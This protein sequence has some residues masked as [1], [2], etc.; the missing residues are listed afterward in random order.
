MGWLGDWVTAR[1]PLDV[2]RLLQSQ[3]SLVPCYSVGGVLGL[4]MKVKGRHGKDGLRDQLTAGQRAK[5]A[6]HMLQ[7]LVTSGRYE[8]TGR[9]RCLL[10]LEKYCS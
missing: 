10:M 5:K 9:S 4:T 6:L 7:L 1:G 8:G 3:I 2:A